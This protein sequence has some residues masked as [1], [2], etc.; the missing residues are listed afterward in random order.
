VAVAKGV[1]SH[2]KIRN[3]EKCLISHQ[4][5]QDIISAILGF[6][7]LCTYKL[8]KS[9]ASIIPNRV[10]SDVIEN[11]FCQQRTM[12]N[13]ANANPTYL[14]YC[15]TMNSVILGQASVSNDEP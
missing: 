12:H 6:E 5:R 11:I 7:E 14:G 15:H 9:N 4:T 10:N 13:G 3:K 1:K 8:K 2:E